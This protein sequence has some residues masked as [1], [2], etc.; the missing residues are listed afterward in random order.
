MQ[1]NFKQG[2][3]GEGSKVLG[4]W[5]LIR[6]KVPFLF[7]KECSLIAL[8]EICLRGYI[9]NAGRKYCVIREATN[10]LVRILKN[11][12]TF[13]NNLGEGEVKNHDKTKR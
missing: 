5:I 6:R 9:C 8:L 11:V 2:L 10:V 3:T 12:F 7:Q 13:I 4:C 1:V